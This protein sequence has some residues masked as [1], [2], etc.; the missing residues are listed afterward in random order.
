MDPEK[1]LFARG[2]LE[3]WRNLLRGSGKRESEVGCGEQRGE[4]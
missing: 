4:S 2:R 1:K 3:L